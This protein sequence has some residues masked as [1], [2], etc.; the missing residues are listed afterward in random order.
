MSRHF[1][2]SL[3][4]GLEGLEQRL[5]LS[6]LIGPMKAGAPIEDDEDP[7]IVPDPDPNLPDYPT[8]D[9]EPDP[10][11]FPGFPPPPV[12]PTPPIGGPIGPA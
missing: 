9:P 4:R 12:F 10:G 3:A 2:F 11:D 6:G 1:E 5:S 7:P 8:P